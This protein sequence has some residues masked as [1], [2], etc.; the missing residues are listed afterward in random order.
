M[1]DQFQT[2]KAEL[3]ECLVHTRSVV[4]TNED[5]LN[6]THGFASAFAKLGS[7]TKANPLSQAMAQSFVPCS[8]QLRAHQTRL[9]GILEESLLTPMERLIDNEVKIIT[10]LIKKMNTDRLFLDSCRAKTAALESKEVDDQKALEEAKAA[11]ETARSAYEATKT[12]IEDMCLLLSQRKSGLLTHSLL[13]Y[14][15]AQNAYFLESSETVQTHCTDIWQKMEMESSVD[16]TQKESEQ[17]NM[18]PVE[19]PVAVVEPVEEPVEDQSQ[20]AE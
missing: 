18:E 13:D 7:H 12:K 11:E 17:E 20:G 5:L 6:A 1:L 9:N 4:R 14:T 8:L 10:A 3:K 19:E 16:V 2:N 15:K